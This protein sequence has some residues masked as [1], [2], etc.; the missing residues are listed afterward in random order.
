[1]IRLLINIGLSLLANAVGLIV[2]ASVL[3]DMGLGASGFIIAVL[4][5]TGVMIIVRPM[6]TKMAL[7]HAQALGG[8]SA[9]IAVLVGLIVTTIVSDSMTIDG[10][11]TWVMATVI[12][13]AATLLGGLLLPW[14]LLRKHREN[15]QANAGASGARTWG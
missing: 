4:I 7:T 5:F 9:L 1:M 8:S 12:V 2:A 15:K 11:V 10:A 6:I 3:D 14:L 13:W